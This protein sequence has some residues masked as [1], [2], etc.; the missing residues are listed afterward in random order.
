M[1]KNVRRVFKSLRVV[2]F[3]YIHTYFSF[4]FP[5]IVTPVLWL[6]LLYFVIP[7]LK[8]KLFIHSVV[9]VIAVVVVVVDFVFIYD[10]SC[11][12]FLLCLKTIKKVS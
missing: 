4:A 10:V 5:F 7:L 6:K 11:F 12:V 2:S 3:F 8:N 1:L 9:E